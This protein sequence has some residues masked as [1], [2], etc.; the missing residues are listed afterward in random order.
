MIGNGCNLNYAK[1]HPKV[2]QPP[3]ST[4]K[5]KHLLLPTEPKHMASQAYAVAHNSLQEQE[6]LGPG[7]QRHKKCQRNEHYKPRDSEDVSEAEEL[8]TS[9]WAVI[10]DDSKMEKAGTK[11]MVENRVLSDQTVL[12]GTP[13][14]FVKRKYMRKD[15]CR[16][17]ATDSWD[18]EEKD[19][20]ERLVRAQKR[21]GNLKKL[22]PQQFLKEGEV[23]QDEGR[24]SD[25][26]AASDGREGE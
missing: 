1:K 3:K 6:R 15:Y 11:K 4:P 2:L 12:R 22:Q 24:A 25:P 10:Q 5:H 7:L 19:L 18:D 23:I 21:Q 17:R 26:D 13:W 8:E 20:L 16:T 14:C 9:L